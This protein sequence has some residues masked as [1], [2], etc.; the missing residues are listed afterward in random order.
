MSSGHEKR[1]QF[2]IFLYN[3]RLSFEYKVDPSLKYQY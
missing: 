3:L 1:I 2:H